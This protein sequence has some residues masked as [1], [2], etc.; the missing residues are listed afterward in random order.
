MIK[1][2]LAPLR[3]RFPVIVWIV[4]FPKARTAPPASQVKS[5]KLFEPESVV[6]PIIVTGFANSTVEPFP[7]IVDAE[8]DFPILIPFSAVTTYP[9]LIEIVP[10]MARFL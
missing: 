3:I 9:F 6:L 4:P 7:L 2:S 5:V 10:L 1:F 8:P